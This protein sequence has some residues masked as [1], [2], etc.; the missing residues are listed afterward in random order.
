MSLAAARPF[1]RATDTW[2]VDLP[3][4]T[5]RRELSCSPESVGWGYARGASRH[6]RPGGGGTDGPIMIGA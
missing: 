1:D 6:I 2:E 4:A 5:G 3:G